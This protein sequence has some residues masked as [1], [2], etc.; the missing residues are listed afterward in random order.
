MDPK[1]LQKGFTL[2]AVLF[3]IVIIA[4]IAVL[5]LKKSNNSQKQSLPEVQKRAEQDLEEINKNLENYQQQIEIQ[6]EL[7]GI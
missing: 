2:L 3:S 6:N 7:N 1:N 4:V 5:L